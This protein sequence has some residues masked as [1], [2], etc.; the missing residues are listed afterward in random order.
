M[1]ESSLMVCR[2]AL[3]FYRAGASPL[4]TQILTVEIHEKL[5]AHMEEVRRVAYLRGWRDAKAKR[6]KVTWYPG[7]FEVLDWE[8]REAGL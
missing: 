7:W 6:K 5:R 3:D 4:E 2:D 8:R 1:C